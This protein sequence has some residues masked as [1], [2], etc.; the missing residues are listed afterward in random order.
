MKVAIIGMSGRFPGAKNAEEYWHNLANGI[1][2]IVEMPKSRWDVDKHEVYSKWIGELADIDKFDPLFFNIS[3][4]EAEAMDPQQRVFLEE[5]WKALDDAGYSKHD[6]EPIQCGT[7]V[8]IMGNEYA[9]MFYDK[10]F[11]H[12]AQI[13]TG[14]SSAIL[15]ARLAYFLNL[16]GPAIAVNT[17]CSASLV[18][19]HLA[20]QA[21][22][23]KE[24]DLA[25]A[26]GVN[27]Y[28]A[29]ESYKQ[30]CD[31][32][33]LSKD[34]KCYSF[35][36]RANGFVP[37]EGAGAIILKRLEDAVRDNDHIYGVIAASAINQDGKTNGI[38]A[39]SVSS[40][41]R[42]ETEVYNKFNID[43][44]TI[45]YIETHGTATKLGD[46]ME[47]E[48]LTTTYRK[49]TDKKQYCAIG[50]VKSNIG[51]TSAAAGMASIQKVLLS[52]QNKKIPPSINYEK[53][54]E[55][56][57][58]ENSPFFVNTK[59]NDWQTPNNEKRR[60]AVS[61][62]GFSGTNAHLVIEEYALTPRPPLPEGEGENIIVFSTKTEIAFQD[63]VKNL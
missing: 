28:M 59:L 31:A 61:S 7:Y 36:D 57:D 18:A 10:S 15:A 37:G 62:F 45:S 3:P 49:F 26:G 39:P 29:Y 56:I 55:N 46:P 42:L 21:L 17:A 48:A 14:N 25:V 4:V 35:D 24:I 47:I 38:T 22:Q 34:G 30:M 11:S 33:M 58:F 40:Q 19:T 50:S 32:G 23:T 16:T 12:H 60:S 27:F 9:S 20:Y 43:P 8:G 1:S 51:H 2:S 13:M 41:I 6:S 53:P 63:T 5:A 44:E 52:L 54:N